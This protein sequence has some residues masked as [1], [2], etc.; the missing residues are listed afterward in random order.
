M[1]AFTVNKR[2]VRKVN[3]QC[4]NDTTCDVGRDLTR[5]TTVTTAEPEDLE[6][7]RSNY[8]VRHW[9]GDLSLPISFWVNGAVISFAIR[10]E[11]AFLADATRNWESSPFAALAFLVVVCAVNVWQVV[12]IWRSATKYVQHETKVHWGS[13]AKFMVVIGVISTISKMIVGAL[14][15][16]R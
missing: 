7:K 11:D 5:S 14:S 13:V 6:P 4:K 2:A 16:L 15:G 8:F 10:V 12:G 3:N 1:R 9:R